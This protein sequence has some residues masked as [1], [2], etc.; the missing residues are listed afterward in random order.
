MAKARSR[1]SCSLIVL[2][3]VR[4]GSG[5]SFA[6]VMCKVE[7]ENPFE[8]GRPF[9]H[10]GMPQ[11]AHGILVAG[12]PMLL[13]RQARELVVLR[14][15]LVMLRAIDQMDDAVGLVVGNAAQ[16]LCLLTVAE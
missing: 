8:V 16:E 12:A 11:R 9:Q 4:Y 1:T 14:V 15:A 5:G 7:G 10:L 2:S 6:A 3:M 13:H